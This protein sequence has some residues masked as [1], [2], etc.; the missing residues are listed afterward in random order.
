MSGQGCS[1]LE[2]VGPEPQRLALSPPPL[3][4]FFASGFRSHRAATSWARVPSVCP[5]RMD[6]VLPGSVR[7][8]FLFEPSAVGLLGLRSLPTRS[9]AIYTPLLGIRLPRGGSARNH[10]LGV[11]PCKATSA[12]CL[13]SERPLALSSSASSM[14]RRGGGSRIAE[15]TRAAI[16]PRTDS[17]NLGSSREI[18]SRCS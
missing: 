9:R 10:L 7:A 11:L 5:W 15:R 2:E 16:K 3:L 14:L 6:V 17:E 1:R 18:V 12:I 4:L 13:R 8:A